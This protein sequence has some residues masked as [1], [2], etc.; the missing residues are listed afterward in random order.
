M[1]ILMVFQTPPYPPDLGSAK[2]NFPFFRENVKRHE[3]SVLSFGS[4]EDERKFREAYGD[5]CKHITFVNSSRPRIINLAFRILRL[6][7]GNS[8]YLVFYS[9]KMDRAIKDIVAREKFDLIHCCSTI[10]GY[11][12]LPKGIPLV[13]DTHNVEF[14]IMFRVY[15]QTKNFIMKPYYF[16]EYQKL[17]EDETRISDQFDIVVTTTERDKRIFQEQLPHK[18]I[19]VIPNGVEQSFFTRQQIAEEPRSIVFTGLMSYMPN[20]HGISWFLD[21]IFPLIL[22]QEPAAKLYVVGA[23]PSKKL[24]LRSSKNVVVTGFVDDVKPYFARG[25]VFVIPLL[26]GGGIR[27]KALEAMA[28]RRPIVTTSVGCEGINLKHEE[29]ALFADTP[30]AFAKCVLRLFNDQSLRERLPEN[31]HKNLV[32][33]YSWEKSGLELEGVY[34]S[35]VPTNGSNGSSHNAQNSHIYEGKRFA[36]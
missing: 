21:E 3:V 1:K 36:Y 4:P 34:Q 16:S 31:A 22:H 23:Q 35:L 10:L 14:D 6:V 5:K 7:T 15:Q 29:S 8:S 2:R 33:G 32:E 26:I 30:D 24:R 28:M 11:H 27:G 18:Q 19:R 9:P 25:Q 20:H 12:R 13:G 17:K